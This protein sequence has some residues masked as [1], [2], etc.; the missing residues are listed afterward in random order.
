[1]AL[2]SYTEADLQG[3]CHA[4]YEGDNDTPT[5]T[6]DEYLYRRTLMNVAVNRW[7]NDKGQ[8]WNELWTDTDND[9]T[10]ADLGISTAD[11]EYETPDNF[12]F[13][14]GYLLIT[15]SGGGVL[16]KLPVIKPEQA[17]SLAT[18][19]EFA[20]V[21][22]NYKDGHKLVI[23]SGIATDYNGKNLKY[24]FYKR[25][26][27]FAAAADESEM[28]D[29]MYVVHSVCAELFK[30]DNNLSLYTSH[31][32]EA[33][34][35]LRQMEILNMMDAPLQEFENDVMGGILGT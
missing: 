14:G 9:S 6:D 8:L 3:F 31:L 34:E 33:E 35:R 21:K 23:P 12:R 16:K 29:P 28:S 18:G 24:D 32:R 13:M 25:A 10:G 2:V 7:E 1:M 20:Y 22:G 11:T 19:E 17:Q 15:D 5:T 26:T 30:S 4:I 27:K